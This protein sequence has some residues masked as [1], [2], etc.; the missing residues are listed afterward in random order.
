FTSVKKALSKGGIYVFDYV[1]R[2][3][4]DKM[5]PNN[6]FIDERENFTYIWQLSQEDGIDFIES[7]YFVKNKIG[8]YDKVR[9]VYTKK[10]YRLEKLE[11]IIFKSGLYIVYKHKNSAIAGSR[12]IFTL[13]NKE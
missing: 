5:F 2:E 8:T 6:L 4:M 1:D 3:F 9:E 13:Q 11:E 7:I 10:I 12:W